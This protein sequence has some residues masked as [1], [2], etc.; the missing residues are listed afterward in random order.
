MIRTFGLCGLYTFGGTGANIALF[1]GMFSNA[2]FRFV[3][4]RY[5]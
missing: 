3:S 5:L 4:F 2:P 1:R